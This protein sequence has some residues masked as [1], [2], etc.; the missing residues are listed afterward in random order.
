[1]GLNTTD[2]NN[3]LSTAWGGNYVNDFI[4]RGRVKRVLVEGDAPYR[5]APSDLDQWTVRNNL[6]EMVPFNSFAQ[7]SW[8]LA[9][10]TLSRF[11]GIASYEFQGQAAP[12]TSSG[13]AMD[14]MAQLAAQI[15]GVS[16][17][18]A[19]QSYQERLSSGQAPLL[20][21]I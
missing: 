4:D 9:P 18:W 19:G 13:Q 17:A 10:V 12:G 5:A 6:D 7:T 16:V 1:L 15:P 14:R 8:S 21:G 3:T 2:V 11:Q 20:Y